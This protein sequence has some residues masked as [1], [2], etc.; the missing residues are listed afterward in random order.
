MDGQHNFIPQDVKIG[1]FEYKLSQEEIWL[2]SAFIY[3]LIV[4]PVLLILGLAGTRLSYYLALKRSAPAGCTKLG[5]R[6]K[7]SLEPGSTQPDEKSDSGACRIKSLWIYPIKS[8]RGIEL[9]HAAVVNTGLQYDRQFCFAQLI[10]PFPVSAVDS[11]AKRSAHKWRF[12]TQREFPL[13]S[14]VRTELWAPDPVSPGYSPDLLDVRAS[15]AIIVRFPFQ[16][17]GWRGMLANLAA[18]LRGGIPERSFR[19]PFQPSEA[20]IE[21]LFKRE[22]VHIWNDSPEGVNMSSL[23]PPELR[24]AIGVRNPLGLFR[25]DVRREVTRMT[26]S[27]EALGWQA[28]TGFADAFPIHVMGGASVRDLSGRQPA[29]SPPLDI[30]RFRPNVVVEGLEPY[31][32]DEW[33]RVRLGEG[34]YHVTG[35]CVRCRLPN[36]NPDTGKRHMKEPDRTLRAERDVDKGAPG[37]GCLGLNLVP[38]RQE[39]TVR[40]GDEVVVLETGENVYEGM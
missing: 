35:R 13:L 17:D 3:S 38:A 34:E 24:Y 15:G 40:V 23:L 12:V 22:T 6:H 29:G 20:D 31:A 21:K 37:K 10:S 19:I 1:T 36:V 25:V 16:D 7:S 30:R 26:P 5:I 14:Q 8:C 9:D 4:A 39:G 28:V 11:K 32:E 2:S 18:K 33:K 27:K